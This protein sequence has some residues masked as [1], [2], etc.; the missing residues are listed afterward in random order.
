MGSFV[1]NATT[2][3]CS[4]QSSQLGLLPTPKFSSFSFF[5]VSICTVSLPQYGVVNV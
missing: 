3:I 4:V 1:V 2:S 5:S